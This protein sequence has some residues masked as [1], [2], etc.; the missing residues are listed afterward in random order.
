MRILI[1]PW[2]KSSYKN[3]NKYVDEYVKMGI[4]RENIDVYDYNVNVNAVSPFGTFYKAYDINKNNKKDYEIV[5]S[6]SGGSFIQNS[7]QM[8]GWE[9]GKIVYDSGP[10]FVKPECLTQ[11]L[12]GYGV[13]NEG[14]RKPLNMGTDILWGI[15][16][17]YYK[18][19]KEYDFNKYN[20]L[21]FPKKTPTL[22]FN[23]SIDDII[24][25]DEIKDKSKDSEMILY[26]N[27]KHVQHMRYNYED[28]IENLYNFI[29]KQ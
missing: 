23:S 10:M 9:F 1:I 12:I 29:Y 17:Y 24:L 11:Y 28:Y 22:L 8:A 4:K 18:K 20:K 14:F 16:K 27:S 7:L 25:F 3:I 21:L 19:Y 26:D 13:I 6:F 15:E 2:F 5:H